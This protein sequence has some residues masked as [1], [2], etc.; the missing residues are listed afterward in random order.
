MPMREFH[1]DNLYKKMLD[2]YKK[3]L[4]SSNPIS[5]LN[6]N[7][8]KFLFDRLSI[9]EKIINHNKI[10]ADF[11]SIEDRFIFLE[12][13]LDV[14]GFASASG[15]EDMSILNVNE[16]GPRDYRI[17]NLIKSNDD[18]VRDFHFSRL[19]Q[20]WWN[21]NHK[22]NKIKDLD[23]N[24]NFKAGRKCDYI[25]FRPNKKIELIECNR[26]HPH[27][28][29][30]NSLNVCIDKIKNNIKNKAEQQF[31]ETLKQYPSLSENSVCKNF[32]ID[33]TSYGNK[34]IKSDVKEIEIFGFDEQEINYIKENL[35]LLKDATNI[36]RITI[37][38]SQRVF[39]DGLP[40]VPVAIRQCV[41]PVVF[42][43]ENGS[44][45]N[46]KGWTV[47]G[48]PRKEDLGMISELRVSSCYR[49]LHWI[50]GSFY[51]ETDQ[52]LTWGEI[53]TFGERG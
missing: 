3:I 27:F 53:E 34:K 2:V 45:S 38:W 23:L 28:Q 26:I 8:N 51:S 4:D 10:S 5:E 30:S 48:Y 40:V 25:I 36:D 47:E 49:D 14:Y 46:Y 15:S 44:I 39:K 33:I 17:G 42:N 20:G 43:E 35:L 50:K 1:V 11:L 7:R 21:T 24:P 6:P 18:N 12:T 22:D 37:C 41:N 31:S 32:L 29:G 16:I 19:F 9:L 52:L 13:L